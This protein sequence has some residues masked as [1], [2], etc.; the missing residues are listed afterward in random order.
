MVAGDEG[1]VIEYGA[2]E[3][4]FDDGG[5]AEKA[6]EGGLAGAGGEG[7]QQVIEGEHTFGQG[8]CGV[9]GSEGQ[10][11]P[12]RF[13]TGVHTAGAQEGK[14]GGEKVAIHG[15]CVVFGGPRGG[16]SG[17]G[18]YVIEIA[19]IDTDSLRISGTLTQIKGLLGELDG[20]HLITCAEV[21]GTQAAEGAGQIIGDAVAA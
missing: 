21:S 3:A 1:A 4:G 13:Q 14:H 9:L 5:G 15:K 12:T 8:A 10:G 16:R 19:A 18:S 17:V 11:L 2:I 20:F 7:G 6:V